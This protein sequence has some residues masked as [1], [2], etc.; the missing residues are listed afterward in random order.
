M[1]S[2]LL[3]F[4]CLLRACKPSTTSYTSVTMSALAMFDLD[5]FKRAQDRGDYVRSPKFVGRRRSHWIWY[6]F[7]QLS[8]L[9]ASPPAVRFGIDGVEEAIA[10]LR[11]PL[12]RERLVTISL[13]AL[14]HVDP[15]RSIRLTTL[16]GSGID[17]IKLV[18]SMTLFAEV[19][20]HLE[21][22]DPSSDLAELARAGRRILA[23]ASAREFPSARSHNLRSRPSTGH[24]SYRRART[25]ETAHTSTLGGRLRRP[26]EAHARASM[27]SLRRCLAASSSTCSR[28]AMFGAGS[29]AIGQSRAA[30]REGFSG[31]R[32]LTLEARDLLHHP[33]CAH[34]VSGWCSI[35]RTDRTMI[36][37]QPRS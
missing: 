16:M 2:E 31:V 34:S 13:A 30:R 25:C 17:A 12:L 3:C 21:T 29:R 4:A 9:G 19:A 28:R 24:T 1:P 7:P 22:L 26:S 11:D 6:V 18:S 35:P 37:A 10:Y 14:D 15:P 33:R 36:N 27:S 5:R 8:G 20:T 23:E 32:N